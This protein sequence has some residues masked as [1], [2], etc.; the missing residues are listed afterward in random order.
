MRSVRPAI[1]RVVPRAPLAACHRPSRHRQRAGGRQ[2]GGCLLCEEGR[3]VCG[4][5]PW[6]HEVSANGKILERCLS[7]AEAQG[8]ILQQL[9]GEARF[10]HTTRE[11]SISLDVV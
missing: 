3:R 1:K 10:A 6:P 9:A 4:R 2:A 7:Y 5:A 11:T 8:P